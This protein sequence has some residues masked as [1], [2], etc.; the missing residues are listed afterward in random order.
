MALRLVCSHFR[1][2]S[3]QYR[4]NRKLKL[5]SNRWAPLLCLTTARF[6]SR[7]T[8][9]NH[10]HSSKFT[11]RLPSQC[12]EFLSSCL[13]GGMEVMMYALLAL[14][15]SGNHAFPCKRDQTELSSSFRSCHLGFINSSTSLMAS[16]ASQMIR[17]KLKTSMEMRT[18]R[19]WFNRRWPH[20]NSS[21]L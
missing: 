9:S 4:N 2:T 8:I 10:L 1:I 12:Q 19:S 21:H 20:S 5:C 7:T 11:L 6:R 3:Q 14:G 16:G 13:S 18:I 15:T 17:R